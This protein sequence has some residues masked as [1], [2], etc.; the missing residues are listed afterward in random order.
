MKKF[1]VI[2]IVILALMVSMLPMNTAFAKASTPLI[3]VRNQTGAP[4]TLVIQNA[5]KTRSFTFATGA[6]VISVSADTY[7]Y[8][9]ETACGNKYGTLNMSRAAVLHFSCAKGALVKIARPLK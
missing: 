5:V 6:A 1:A 4:V 8:V 2:T 7:S 9:A 3:T